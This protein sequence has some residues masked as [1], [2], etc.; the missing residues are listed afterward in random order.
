MKEAIL[1]LHEDGV[2][3]LENA[4]DM[5][6][7]DKLNSRMLEEI[8]ELLQIPNNRFDR[9]NSGN[10]SQTPPVMPGWIFPD[11]YDN[12]FALQTIKNLLGPELEMRYLRGNTAVSNSRGR[13]RVHSDFN[14]PNYHFNFGYV[15]NI[16]MTDTTPEKGAT[17]MWLGTHK[18]AT[19]EQHIASNA[20]FIRPELVEERRKVCPP[21]YPSMK[22]GS[23][24]VR[25]LRM[26]HAGIANKTDESRIM[27]AF[28][29]LPAWYQNQKRVLLPASSEPEISKFKNAKVAADYV[30]DEKYNYHLLVRLY[31]DFSSGHMKPEPM[32]TVA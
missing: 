23:L 10:L 26:W 20:T 31:A 2:V 28:V 1:A 29:Y 18:D 21:V 16:M 24:I 9:D 15:V 17:E 3:V 13:Q 8:P 25:D 5:A 12:V 7:I 22:K 6:H 32:A 14:F 19:I 30:D 27:L 4:V 11:I